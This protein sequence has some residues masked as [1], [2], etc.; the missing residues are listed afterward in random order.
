[1]HDPKI[2]IR[3]GT[4]VRLSKEKYELYDRMHWICYHLEFEHSDYDPDEPCDHPNCPWNRIHATKKMK[5]WDPLWPTTIYSED[6]RSVLRIKVLEVNALGNTQIRVEVD[7]R[8][9]NKQLDLWIKDEAWITFNAA[10]LQLEESGEGEALLQGMDPG[11]LEIR[12][13]GYDSVSSIRLRYSLGNNAWI[14]G[15]PGFAVSGGFPLDPTRLTQIR[16][17]LAKLRQIASNVTFQRIEEQHLPAILDIYQYYVLNTTATFHTVI[18]TLDEMRV[19]VGMEHPVYRS[20]VIYDEYQICGYVV[21]DQHKK[22]E[23]YDGTGEVS[24]YLRPDF[25]GKSIGG[26]ALQHIERYAREKGLHVLAATISGKNTR[27]IRLFE[28]NGYT[29]CAHYKEVGVKFGQ[30]LDVVAY[31]KILD[32]Q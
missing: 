28:R 25:V 12:I 23:A 21:L 24:V 1:M 29:K 32:N 31:Q 15:K 9:I 19:M 26:L 7:D 2:C 13:E 30:Y 20:F 4:P 18:P 16:K 17:S 11:G 27:S 10:L 22:R 5:I 3:C 6:R 14:E 8:G